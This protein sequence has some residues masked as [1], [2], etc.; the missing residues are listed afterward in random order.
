MIAMKKNIIVLSNALGFFRLMENVIN[1][2]LNFFTAFDS[3][4]TKRLD[5]HKNFRIKSKNFYNYL[6]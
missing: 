2:F 5:S 1:S 3:D 6:G 4:K